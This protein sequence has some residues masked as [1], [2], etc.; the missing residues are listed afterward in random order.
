MLVILFIV[1][2]VLILIGREFPM[3]ATVAF[4]GLLGNV[5]GIDVASF[6][7]I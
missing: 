2:I 5:I 6:F 7:G 1:G 4:L 3:W